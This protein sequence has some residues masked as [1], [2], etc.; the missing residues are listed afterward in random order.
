MLNS[1]KVP[2]TDPG[3]AKLDN[4][5]G[6]G[7]RLRSRSVFSRLDSR[8]L[9]PPRHRKPGRSRGSYP[10]RV[11]LQCADCWRDS[12]RLHHRQ[13]DLVR[14]N[15]VRSNLGFFKADRDVGGVTVTGFMNDVTLTCDGGEDAVKTVVG[16]DGRDGV[17]LMNNRT[18][19]VVLPP[20]GIGAG[21]RC[22]VGG[23]RG[24]DNRAASDQR[25]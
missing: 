11:Q 6:V 14:R 13:P 25:I 7:Y 18:G 19:S 3:I 10:S 17:C 20:H 12:P 24:K 2:Y 8:W 1:A 21:K 9:C 23:L 22:T 4:A 15:H 5:I 16:S